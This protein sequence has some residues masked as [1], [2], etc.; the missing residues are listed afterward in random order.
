MKQTKEQLLAE[1]QKIEEL[2]KAYESELDFGEPGDD[3]DPHGGEADEAEE[4]AT[5]LGVKQVLQKRLDAIG[6]ELQK[7][8]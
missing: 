2:L 1:K 3:R 7:L 4:I 8:E 5:Y 6:A